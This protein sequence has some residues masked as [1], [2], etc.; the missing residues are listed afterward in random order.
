M[1]D[2]SFRFSQR[3]SF[4]LLRAG[5]LCCFILVVLARDPRD[6]DPK[7]EDI[8]N[9]LTWILRFLP[10]FC[11]GNGLYSVINMDIFLFLAGENSSTSVWS[12]TILL[13]DVYF[14][15][16]QSLFYPFLA[17]Q[18]DIWSTNPRFMSMLGKCFYCLTCKNTS[19][20]K[21]ATPIPDDG[22]VLAEEEAV[23][24]A[25]ADRKDLILIQN[26]TKVYDSGKLAVDR[27]S[28][29]IAPGECFGLL[30]I[31]GAGKT[32]T[33][34]MLTAEFPP[35]SGDAILDGFSVSR[36]PQKT[37]RKIGYCPQFDAHFANLTGREHVELYAN[38][39]GIPSRLNAQAVD[40]KLREVGLS[41]FD[42][43]R[44]SSGY[45]GGMKRRLSLACATIGQPQI[46]FLD[47]CSTGVD[48][49]A[50]EDIWRMISDMVA[51]RGL[52]QAEKPSVILT[53]HSM[54]ECEALCPRI[55]I[56]ANGRLRCL[57][58]AQRLKSK[59][60]QGFQV[61]LKAHFV[62][63]DDD[64]FEETA[65][66]LKRYK[67]RSSESTD[68][69]SLQ[70]CVAALDRLSS[71]DLLS[72]KVSEKENGPGYNVWKDATSPVGVSIDELA[73]FATT[74]LRMTS[75]E[76]FVSDTFPTYVL[77]ERQDTK[78]RYEVKG[79]GLRISKI[80][81]SIEENKE[82]LRLTD[83]SVSQ[84]SL[85]QVFNL[86]AAEAEKHKQGPLDRLT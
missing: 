8:S 4:L 61:E 34:K 24:S 37:R 31:N 59:F 72:K 27:L 28:L 13:Y 12:G 64:D 74:E 3:I 63:H 81:A 23:M 40:E 32:T 73:E 67:P 5:P 6:P 22:D 55:G 39:K 76:K 9:I 21:Q 26:L 51:G 78:A 10:A 83:Y 47:E 52:P 20:E 70:D 75:L 50:R 56:M 19:S 57:G 86:H 29:G 53:T 71:N 80:F 7:L 44:L 85:E 46:V 15:A 58:S 1:L 48:P 49:V 79:S 18:F 30:G 11:L 65:E 84:T 38:I 45:S 42:S 16:A 41:T 17:I 82:E 2:E 54:E 62:D 68:F 33:M 77:R 14:L 36:E 66:L 43:N 60:G 25:D 69:F 35:T